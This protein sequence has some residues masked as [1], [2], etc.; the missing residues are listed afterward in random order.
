MTVQEAANNSQAERWVLVSAILASSMGFIDSSALNV[1]LP[2]IQASLGATGTQL[3]WVV[4]GYLLMLAALI[5]I[6]GS[7][8]DRLGRKRVFSIGIAIFIAGS[9]GSGLS[10][11][12]DALIFAR[13]IQGI[14]G[15]LM[16][17]GSLALIT[18]VYSDA[19]RGQ[20]I[21]TW[22]AVTTIVTVIGP[23]LGGVLSG[24]GLWRFIFLINIPIGIAALYILATRV[25][26]SADP[27]AEP[28][29]YPGAVTVTVALA[30]LT[31]GFISAPSM[32]FGSPAVVISLAVGVVAAGVFIWIESHSRYPM[33]PLS[34]FKSRVFSGTNLLTF[35]LYGALSAL[36]FFMALNLV[37]VQGY[38][39]AQAGLAFLPFSFFLA[40]LSRFAGRWADQHGFRIPLILGPAIVGLG[41]LVLSQ[42]GITSGPS[43]Y[44][45]TFFPGVILFGLGMGITVAPLTST[46]M[47]AVPREHAGTASGVNNAVSRT[48]GVLT[49]AVLGALALVVF[50]NQLQSRIAGMNLPPPVKQSLVANAGQ[51]G[52]TPLPQGVQGQEAIQVEA[53]VKQSF[54]S[55][56]GT[57]MLVS[58]GMAFVAAGITI[59]FIHPLRARARAQERVR[60]S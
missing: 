23:V 31:Y 20:A 45:T 50:Q 13:I 42:V 25:P 22:S 1:A 15:A 17:P 28:I 46:V 24:A 2:T 3:L 34:L 26:E 54:A 59:F 38:S 57:I 56:F 49:I 21:G 10:P 7:L 19:R 6:G 4:N 5:L 14:G 44:W 36:S 55:M 27:E 40:G 48:A 12:T 33:L 52:N 11:T 30:G 8:G 47:G 37:Q 18:A 35:F 41:F 58:A 60:T 51:L 16:I 39:E 43:A 29:D 32:G 53:A 9:L